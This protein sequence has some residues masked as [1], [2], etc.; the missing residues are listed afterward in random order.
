MQYLNNKLSIV[1]DQG[2]KPHEFLRVPTC[3]PRIQQNLLGVFGEAMKRCIEDVTEVASHTDKFPVIT[4]KDM[5]CNIENSVMAC[6]TQPNCNEP[7]M[8]FP[9][10]MFSTSGCNR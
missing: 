7:Q 2:K 1:H 5:M 4:E 8:Q 3:H 9:S 10:Q 6:A